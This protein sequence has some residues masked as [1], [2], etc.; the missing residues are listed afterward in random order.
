MW[1]CGEHDPANSA[2]FHAFVL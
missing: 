1:F 2:H